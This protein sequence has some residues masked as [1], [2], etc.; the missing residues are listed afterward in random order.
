[1]VPVVC[2]FSGT[3]TP[4]IKGNISSGDEMIYHTP[5]S[6]YYDRTRIDEA[7]GERWFCTAGEAELA[8]W[9]P[10]NVTVAA[11]TPTPAPTA[12]QTAPTATAEPA[13]PDGIPDVRI[14]FIFFDGLTPTTE[15]DEYAEITNL[16]TATQDLD[17]W[18][19]VDFSDG[20]P[21]LYFP[22]WQLGPGASVRVYTN[23]VHPESGGFSFGRGTAVWSN[24]DPDTAG[25]FDAGGQLVSTMSY[26]PGEDC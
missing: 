12:T 26:S 22:P 25:L 4:V 5:E 24:C 14:T 3:D 20:T 19:L 9:R 18:R 10:P 7:G 13:G 8:G 23:E 16:G 11:D 6:P 2:E 1:M 17:G 21:V 15:R